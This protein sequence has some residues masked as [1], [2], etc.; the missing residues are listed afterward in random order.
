MVTLDQVRE[1][2]NLFNKR[3][4]SNPQLCW[5]GLTHMAGKDS[6][7]QFGILVPVGFTSPRAQLSV[8]YVC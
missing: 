7:E 3:I 4:K 5:D 1:A 8:L 6:A 2:S